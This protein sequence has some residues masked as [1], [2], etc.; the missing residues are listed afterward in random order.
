MTKSKSHVVG[1]LRRNATRKHQYSFSGEEFLLRS[2]SR[3]GA[4]RL[5]CLRIDFCSSYIC[6]LQAT[7]AR[8]LLCNTLDSKRVVEPMCGLCSWAQRSAQTSR[9]LALP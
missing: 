9:T 8:L 6:Q 5:H 2:R 4:G 1:E 7:K 3:R